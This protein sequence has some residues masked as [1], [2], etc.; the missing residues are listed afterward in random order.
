MEKKLH[1]P[2]EGG[3]GDDLGM[4]WIQSNLAIAP[5]PQLA[6]KN[7]SLYVH[8]VYHACYD[9][10][11][12]HRSREALHICITLCMYNAMYTSMY[13]SMKTSMYNSYVYFHVYL[14]VYLSQ[15]LLAL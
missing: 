5:A 3:V 13:T 4:G 2:E 1:R 8:E 6:A 12:V 14:H 10:S 9:T 15:Q 11:K 7:V